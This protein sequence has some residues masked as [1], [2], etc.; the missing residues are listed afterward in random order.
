[1]WSTSPL[2][3]GGWYLDCAP[4]FT[5]PFETKLR[6]SREAVGKSGVEM[7]DLHGIKDEHERA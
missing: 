3:R 1:M 4:S 5:P 2:T 7:V 6:K